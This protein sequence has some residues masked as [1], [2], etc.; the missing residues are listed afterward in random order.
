MHWTK[1]KIAADEWKNMQLNACFVKKINRINKDNVH[2]AI[3]TWYF[4]ASGFKSTSTSSLKSTMVDVDAV[5][6]LFVGM[7]VVPPSTG[8]AALAIASDMRNEDVMALACSIKTVKEK[9]V[10]IRA[11]VVTQ[12]NTIS[13]LFYSIPTIRV[14]WTYISIAVIF[15]SVMR[16]SILLITNT[17]RSFSRHAWSNTVWVWLKSV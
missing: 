13:R 4:V 8:A 16:R 15:N 5:L 7:L 9:N 3:V 14:R 6:L 17:Q 10:C 2:F 12:S 1:V 11:C